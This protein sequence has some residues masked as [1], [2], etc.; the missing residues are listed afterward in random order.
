LCAD[1]LLRRTKL[2]KIALSGNASGTGTFTLASP[3]S[4]TDRTLNLPDN[5]GTVLTTATPGVPVNGPAFR[6]FNSGTQS[7]ANVTNTKLVCNA[8]TFD[9]AGAF[10]STTNYRFTPQTAGYYQVNIS[11]YGFPSAAG[12]VAMKLFKNGSEYAKVEVPNSNTGPQPS[13]SSL[14]YLNGS[15]DYI[16]IYAFQN[17]GGNL[18]MAAAEFSAALARAA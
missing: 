1:G 16:E 17:S 13:G 11:G 15:T 2:S 9:T 10:D 4:N 8:E 12:V 6:A 18:T 3:N 5:S 14:V 7:V